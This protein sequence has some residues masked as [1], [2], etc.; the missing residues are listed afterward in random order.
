VENL[1][2]AKGISRKTLAARSGI[3]ERTLKRWMNGEPAFIENIALIAKLL[4]TTASALIVQ[5]NA[6]PADSL[7]GND[8]PSCTVVTHEQSDEHISLKLQI[9]LTITKG[10]AEPSAQ[11]AAIVE[12]L[13]KLLPDKRGITIT[14]IGAGT[15]IIAIAMSPANVLAVTS[16]E[17]QSAL[18]N[19][20][21][22]AIKPIGFFDEEINSLRNR[23][24]EAAKL[25][26]DL[27]RLIPWKL[28]TLSATRRMLQ[29][30]KDPTDLRTMSLFSSHRFPTVHGL[31]TREVPTEEVEWRGWDLESIGG[32]AESEACSNVKDYRFP[33]DVGWPALS[34]FQKLTLLLAILEHR[35]IFAEAGPTTID[36]DVLG[37]KRKWEFIAELARCASVNICVDVRKELSS[38]VLAS[39]NIVSQCTNVMILSGV[40]RVTGAL[41]D[42]VLQTLSAASDE[43][44]LQLAAEAI[45]A[46]LLKLA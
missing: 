35:W 17:W 26:I 13:Q 7:L 43:M 18:T 20:G 41:L 32:T 5:E 3:H 44:D 16:R 30:Y 21:V 1:R 10:A 29:A 8:A 36:W 14:S 6:G 45:L 33:S 37:G 15:A 22:K 24:A 25:K 34:Y 42:D 19:M 46:N 23:L 2:N 4:G 31:L 11:L 39:E 40:W 28:K 27:A 38:I 9:D 12:F